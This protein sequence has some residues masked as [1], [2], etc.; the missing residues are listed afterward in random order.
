MAGGESVVSWI[1][2]NKK[3]RKRAYKQ[4]SKAVIEASKTSPPLVRTIQ[5]VQGIIKVGE[6]INGVRDVAG[7]INELVPQVT[8]LVEEVA[9][10]VPSIQVM[11]QSFCDNVR[12]FTYF[13]MVATTV[14]I[15]ANLVLTY[16]G[17][18]ALDLIAARLEDISHALAAQTALMAQK[19]FAGYVYDMIRERLGQTSDDPAC[20]H[21]FFLYH[22]DNDWYPKFYHLLEEKPVGP[23]F[24]G[25]TNQIDTVFVFMLAARRA[26]E[27]RERRA[28][29]GH[30]RTT[31]T[32][33]PVKLHLLIPAYQPIL[34]VEALRI[35]DEIGDFVIEG[36]I[37]SNRE[38]VWLNLQ[39]D[40]RRRYATG[41]G[42]WDPPALGIWGRVLTNIG[43][44]RRPPVLTEP[45]TLGSRQ[46]ALEEVDP[47]AT[48]ISPDEK[49]GAAESVVAVVPDLKAL[50]NGNGQT[51]P[52]QDRHGAGQRR[53]SRIEA[54]SG[55]AVSRSGHSSGKRL[56]RV[57]T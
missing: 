28:R 21:W 47:L 16:Q 2:G 25:Y 53:S 24:C 46:H 55:S 50:E 13:N 11:G 6:A 29:A 14:G 20:D 18:Q 48:L 8:K 7:N 44:A 40:Q 32:P 10:F 41:I 49:G 54:T 17:I 42:Q 15:G 30:A 35:P 1:L 36:R 19:D 57:L 22:P 43:L 4:V 38:F 37:N 9:H 26:I 56:S 33:R 27:E 12:I 51:T 34:I 3:L 45:R 23:A 39:P 5:A 31:A 52:L